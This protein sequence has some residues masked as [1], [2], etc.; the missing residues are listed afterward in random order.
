MSLLNLLK[1]PNAY[2]FS[3]KQRDYLSNNTGGYGPL[4]GRK[5]EFDVNDE[6]AEPTFIYGENY[7]KNNT[8]DVFARGGLKLSNDRRKTDFNRIGKFLK[9]PIGLQFL[10]KQVALQALNPLNPK[11]YNPLNL[12]QSVSLAGLSNVDRGGVLSIG[13][14]NLDDFDVN[15]LFAN[16]TGTD[17]ISDNR[18]FYQDDTQVSFGTGQQF[19][20]LR[21]NN[22]K[23]GDPGKKDTVDG[24]KDLISD[25]NPFAPPMSYDIK[26]DGKID[27]LN[28]LP[29]M[30]DSDLT[31]KLSSDIET[32]AKDFV[33]FRFE[34]HRYDDTSF[35]NVGLE[36]GNHI[37][38]F[39]AF[40]D[41]I[42]DNFKAG[43]NKYKYNGRAES[44][45]TYA[46]FDRKISLGFKIAAQSRWE[47]KP[48]YQKLN[49]LAA[50]TAPNYSANYGRIR[51]PFMYLTVGDWFNR[52]PGVLTSV[53]LSWQKDY[54]WE[55]A[56]DKRINSEG[57]LVG[58][59]KEMLVL[60]H[61]LDV[62]VN[63]QPIHSFAPNNSP[64]A[65]FIGIDGGAQ[66]LLADVPSGTQLGFEAAEAEG[67]LEENLV[68]E[69]TDW[70]KDVVQQN[71]PTYG[72]GNEFFDMD[73]FMQGNSEGN[74]INI[75]KLL[76]NKLLK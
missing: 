10:A 19:S 42:G 6:N 63:F 29:I 74:S 72:S 55:I 38:A 50:Q 48:L 16:T 32:S 44:F 8:E 66:Q 5:V 60:P 23:L 20:L 17:Y 34:I 35:D 18:F 26:M 13:G 71:T 39:R 28:A 22:Y 67:I 1:D 73:K 27:Q 37:I 40:L 3:S 56:L 70:R 24:L 75:E 51:S 2:K 68:E 59:D 64:Q 43:H 47:M 9:T 61:V 76:T 15:N 31:P 30:L 36:E 7:S 45:Y 33:K 21:Y 52:L 49:Y 54:T 11:I 62:S 25:L 65:P 57:N 41:K 12:L 14:V 53:D 69:N 46:S 4:L 58:K